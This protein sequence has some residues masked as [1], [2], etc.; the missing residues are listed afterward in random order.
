MR[1]D[2]ITSFLLWWAVVDDCWSCLLH[3]T[4]HVCE[5]DCRDEEEASHTHTLPTGFFTNS[6]VASAS[7]VEPL[8]KGTP[9]I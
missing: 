7:T 1:T 6:H 2:I 5:P 9:Y 8:I 4:C 3:P